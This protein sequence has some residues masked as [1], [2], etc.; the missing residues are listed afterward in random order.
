MNLRPERLAGALK[1]SLA[2][3]YLIA[4][5]EPLIVEECRD[6]VFAAAQRQGFDERSI[7]HVD[8]R[9]DWST[10]EGQSMEQSLFATRRIVDVRLPTGKPGKEGGACFSRWAAD[11]DPDRLLVV[12]CG[13]WD[14]ASRKAKWASNLASAGVLVE[15]WPIRPEQLPDWVAGRMRAAGLSPEPEAVTLLA[16]H[17]EGNLLAARQ[18]IEKL[19]LLH[20]SGAVSAEQVRASVANNARFDAFRLGEC[21]LGGRGAESLRVANGLCRTGVAIQAVMGALYYQLGQLDG[22]REAVRRGA[23]EA[24][25]MNA[26]RVIR[27]QQPVMR[28]A[29]RRVDGERLGRAFRAM[30]LI[31][32]QS[33][34]QAAG[35]PWLTLDRMIVE[36]T[37]PALRRA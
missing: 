17:V 32:R 6:A 31:D 33:K 23:P 4:G 9:F 3:V 27:M 10:L 34:G 28:Q 13:A 26:Q 20:P 35:D 37:A 22:V 19:S 25:A 29:L 24:Q 1:K 7:F 11:P 5:A 21:L 15:I 12:S 2:P 18:E 30:S 8:A 36:L 16:E 14:G